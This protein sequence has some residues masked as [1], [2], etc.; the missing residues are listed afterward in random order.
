M[1]KKTSHKFAIRETKARYNVTRDPNLE[2]E[3]HDFRNYHI[4]GITF[5]PMLIIGK[6]AIAKVVYLELE[7]TQEQIR[8]HIK[9]NKGGTMGGTKSLQK[10][11]TL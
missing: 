2:I 6:D 8:Q 9:S 3:D 5:P 10:Q 4:N 11:I 7:R 1:C